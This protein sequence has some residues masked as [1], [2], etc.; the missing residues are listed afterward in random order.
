MSQI[1][2]FCMLER[3]IIDVPQRSAFRL[4]IRQEQGASEHNKDCANRFP[5]IHRFSSASIGDA[6][7]LHWSATVAANSCRKSPISRPECSRWTLPSTTKHYRPKS[8]VPIQN[9]AS[10]RTHV[11]VLFTRPPGFR[12]SRLDFPELFPFQFE[13]GQRVRSGPWPPHIDHLNTQGAWY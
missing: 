4:P 8:N 9:S 3:L 7:S 11:G 12:T 13:P 1:H 6:L 10:E 2:V 5:T